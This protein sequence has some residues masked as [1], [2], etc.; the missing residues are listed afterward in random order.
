MLNRNR[1]LFFC[2][3]TLICAS[4]TMNQVKTEFIPIRPLSIQ[5]SE[6][7]VLTYSNEDQYNSAMTDKIIEALNQKKKYKIRA[8][9]KI[10]SDFNYPDKLFLDNPWVDSD[11]LNITQENLDTILSI[12][13]KAKADKILLILLGWSYGSVHHFHLTRTKHTAFTTYTYCISVKERSVLFRM[14][15]SYTGSITTDLKSNTTFSDIDQAVLSDS[16]E[17]ARQYADYLDNKIT[18]ERI[19]Q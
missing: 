1:F 8:Y 7:C 13:E 3:T 19:S 2:I 15:H 17:Y 6:F 10:R 12:G 16:A 11:S 4:C 14:T 9:S 5:D 18:S